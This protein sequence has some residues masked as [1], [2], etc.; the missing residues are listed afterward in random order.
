MVKAFFVGEAFCSE[1][2]VLSIRG[3]DIDVYFKAKKV[4][5]NL[6]Q[7]TILSLLSVD[8]F[9]SFDFLHPLKKTQSKHSNTWL[10]QLIPWT[11]CYLIKSI[12]EWVLQM[13]SCPLHFLKY[14]ITLLPLFLEHYFNLL[15]NE[16]CS[17]VY[18]TIPVLE[19]PLESFT[20]YPTRNYFY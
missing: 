3:R 18:T 11:D 9:Q 13:L 12:L 4:W 20:C 10:S 16:K 2:L 5:E 7:N 19:H 8:F 14:R 17:M 6:I 1:F 15:C